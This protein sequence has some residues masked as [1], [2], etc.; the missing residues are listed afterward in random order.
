[1]GKKIS[2]QIYFQNH[3]QVL[4]IDMVFKDRTCKNNFVPSEIIAIFLLL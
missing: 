2:A 1:M 4:F 3:F